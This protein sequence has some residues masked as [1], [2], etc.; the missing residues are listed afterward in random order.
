MNVL[1]TPEAEQDRD[2]I[3]EYIALDN[4]TAAARMGELFSDVAAQ[5]ARFPGFGCPGKIAIPVN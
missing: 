3:W 1:W 2:D 4:A 5:L